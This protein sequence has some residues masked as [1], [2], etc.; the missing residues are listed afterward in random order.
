MQWQ[1]SF[2]AYSNFTGDLSSLQPLATQ[3]GLARAAGTPQNTQYNADVLYGGR[4]LGNGA[5][6]PQPLN[7]LSMDPNLNHVPE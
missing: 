7:T 5:C 1:F 2:A 3:D 6:V 4:D